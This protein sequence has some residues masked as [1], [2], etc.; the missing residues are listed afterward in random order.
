ME[1]KLFDCSFHCSSLLFSLFFHGLLGRYCL[2]C[3]TS[4]DYEFQWCRSPNFY[5]VKLLMLCKA[6]DCVRGYQCFFMENWSGEEFKGSKVPLLLFSALAFVIFARIWESRGEEGICMQ[7]NDGNAF[8]QPAEKDAKGAC[9][10]SW[11]AAGSA[12]PAHGSRTRACLW[13]LVVGC[14]PTELLLPPSSSWALPPVTAKISSLAFPRSL[15]YPR[16]WG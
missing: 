8:E 5:S 13:R 11:E 9:S 1:W 10:V 14:L 7:I 15:V 12:S 4:N 6:L 16:Y 3:H 2:Q